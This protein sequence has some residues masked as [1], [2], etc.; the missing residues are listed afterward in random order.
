[1]IVQ[2]L[3]LSIFERMSECN[4]SLCRDHDL[5]TK[6]P[7]LRPNFVGA[8]FSPPYCIF[9]SGLQLRDL[10]SRIAVPQIFERRCED[11][12]SLTRLVLRRLLA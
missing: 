4:L 7:A 5:F 12:R 11:Q 8:L 6:A 2:A 10:T 9:R 3:R 1:M